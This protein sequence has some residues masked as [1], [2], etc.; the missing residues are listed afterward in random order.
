MSGLLT[1]VVWAEWVME[2]R[3]YSDQYWSLPHAFSFPTLYPPSTS[4]QKAQEVSLSWVLLLGKD[5]GLNI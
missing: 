3:V 1:E 2:S 5:K 4:A